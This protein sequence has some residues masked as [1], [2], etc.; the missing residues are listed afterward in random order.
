MFTKLSDCSIYVKQLRS[1]FHAPPCTS[2]VARM[3]PSSAVD[4]CVAVE[5]KLNHVGA[6]PLP[7]HVQRTDGV[8]QAAADAAHQSSTTAHYATDSL[9]RAHGPGQT[10]Q[11]RRQK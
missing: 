7:G 10:R 4:E 3:Y 6:P 8:L 9:R 2:F 1:A 5:K 11:L